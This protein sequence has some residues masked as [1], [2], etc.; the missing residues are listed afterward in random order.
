MSWLSHLPAGAVRTLRRWMLAQGRRM[1][2]LRLLAQSRQ[3]ASR[4]AAL[5]ARSSPAYRQL[6]AEQGFDPARAGHP[7]E[8]PHLPV[9]TKQS[10]FG[11]FPPGELAR[12]LP[13]SALADVLT[14]SGRGGRSFGFRLTER[15]QHEDAWFDIDLGLQDVFGVDQKPTLLV[16]CLPMGV[17][18]PSRAVAVANVSVREDMACSILRDI[19][20][21]FA[22]TLVCTDPLFVRALLDEG[23]AAGVDW[24]ALNT[25]VIV[26]EEVLVEAQRDH[27]AAHMGIALDVPAQDPPGRLVGSSFGVG[28][29]GLNL[30]FE[31][32]D[33]IRIRRALREQPVLAQLLG[34]PWDAGTVPSLFCYNPLRCFVEV[35][36]ADAAGYGELCL[37]LLDRHAVLPLPRYAT[38]DVGRLLSIPEAQ[39]AARVAGADMPWLPMVALKGRLQDRPAGMP[40]V[41]S[42]K[43]LLYRDHRVADRLTGAFRL[44]AQPEG[45]A[46]VVLQA[47]DDAAAAD[48]A[49]AGR[50]T[51]LAAQ[52]GLVDVAFEIVGPT[53]FAWRPRLD[54]E[55]KFPYFAG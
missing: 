32:R 51:T 20:P 55:R 2:P 36:A 17:V 16:N 28:E 23:R 40:S 21:R 48:P 1:D 5:A 8:W 25:S 29:L 26:G 43:E 47:S 41:E 52:Q 44:S 3:R 42:I 37:T 10:T 30:L 34:G 9:L 31:T 15:S 35:L 13:A 6:L 12:G 4:M 27:I 24:R 45:R 19:G 22:Q 49:L 18:F 11:R 33:T 53:H 39:H 14:S 46:L 38:G 50:F 54:Y 7:A